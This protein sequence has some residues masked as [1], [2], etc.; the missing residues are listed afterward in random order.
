MLTFVWWR[1]GH[2][3]KIS[4]RVVSNVSCCQLIVWISNQATQLTNFTLLQVK[5]LKL[6]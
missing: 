4:A 3:I 5:R 2:R 6:R 1:A